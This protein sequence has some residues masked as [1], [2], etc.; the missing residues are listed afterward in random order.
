MSKRF[1]HASRACS[2][3]TPRYF[4]TNMLALHVV[5]LVASLLAPLVKDV[6]FG[7]NK[8]DM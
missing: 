2:H 3:A 7:D 4:V 5:K 6:R 1:Q 8:I